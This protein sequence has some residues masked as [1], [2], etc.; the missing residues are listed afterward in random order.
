MSN[1]ELWRPVPGWEGFYAMSN[2]RRVRSE[3]R[4]VMRC[5]GHPQAIEA[6]ILKTTPAGKGL[7]P[8]VTFSAP[9]RREQ[10]YVSALYREVFGRGSH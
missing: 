9:G 6:R 5:S 2:R 3:K 4:V 7:M 1:R 8:R 10:H